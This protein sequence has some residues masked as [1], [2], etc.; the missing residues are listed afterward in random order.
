MNKKLIISILI[1][2]IV[3]IIVFM[4]HDLFFS[5]LEQEKPYE[6]KTDGLN[7]YDSTLVLYDE[8]EPIQVNMDEVRGIAMDNE[9]NLCVTGSLTIV[10]EKNGK[11]KLKFSHDSVAQCVAISDS[12]EIFLGMHGRIEVWSFKGKLLRVWDTENSSSVFFGIVVD[13]NSVYVSDAKE[14]VVLHYDLNGELI[15]KIAGEDSSKGI[16]AI[17]IRSAYFDIALGRDNEIWVVNPGM[18]QLEA[19]DKNGQLK[20]T[21]GEY[22]NE[23]V[24]YFCGCCN[25]THIA[26]LPDGKFVTSEKAIPRVKIYSQMGEFVGFVAGPD[27]FNEGTKG[28]DL[29]VDSENRIFVLDPER[30]QVRVFEKKKDK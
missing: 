10:Y 14:K 6:L 25:P 28:L 1:F 9:D 4:V 26:L 17:I 29:A 24:K 15:N 13:E 30:K 21:W 16:P 7:T 18:H 20:S 8:V 12:G 19:F 3:A 22:S 27:L 2:A 5:N 23:D 11:E